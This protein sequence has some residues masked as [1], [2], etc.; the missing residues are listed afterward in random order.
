MEMIVRKENQRVFLNNKEVIGV[1]SIEFNEEYSVLQANLAGIS[2]SLS[3][4][5]V[6]IK[7]PVTINYSLI[8][9]DLFIPYTGE[10]GF[11][12]FIVNNEDQNQSFGALSGFVDSYNVSSRIGEI[13]SV[14]VVATFYKDFGFIKSNDNVYLGNIYNNIIEKPQVLSPEQGSIIVAS[15]IRDLSKITSF[16]LSIQ[17]LRR[18]TYILGQKLP[19]DIKLIDPLDIN[20]IIDINSK[21][22]KINSSKMFPANKESETIALRINS[23]NSITNL[24][25]FSGNMEL[26]SNTLNYNL[27]ISNVLL[28]YN[29]KISKQVELPTNGL[30]WYYSSQNKNSFPGIGSGTTFW[31]D[32][33]TDE[34]PAKF[35]DILDP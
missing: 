12:L 15:N 7:V 20:L 30:K 23:E 21:D 4:P 26:R 11:D 17:P 14:S 25:S 29:T 18:P 27:G 8:S 31:Y 24:F 6:H 34:Y 19:I 22:F 2:T 33:S 9:Q 5:N 32:L 35:V 10:S 28:N 1:Q 16:S 13:P 3:Y